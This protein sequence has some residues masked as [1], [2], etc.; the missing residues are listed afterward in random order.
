MDRIKLRRELRVVAEE[1][2]MTDP[3]EINAFIK[4]ELSVAYEQ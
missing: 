1:M 2:G 4:E 3:T